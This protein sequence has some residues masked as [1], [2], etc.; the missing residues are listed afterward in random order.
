MSPCEMRQEL[1][2]L[3][4]EIEKVG[5]QALRES[6]IETWISAL[7]DCH[8]AP[9]VLLDMPASM[10]L[11]DRGFSLVHHVL[12]VCQVA[13]AAYVTFNQTFPQP[14]V[15]LDFDV[16]MAGALLHDV[17]KIAEL[18]K[19]PGGWQW[20]RQSHYVRHAYTGVYY[21]MKNHVPDSVLQIIA[22]H[23][24]EADV[25][26]RSAEAEVVHIADD[27]VFKPFFLEPA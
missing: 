13:E 3:L 23:S 24:G 4:P 17:G 11:K 25:I 15:K 14:P 22:Y 2:N 21:A 9:A 8:Q 18:E 20:R 6:V 16:L 5:C 27:M 12:G 1:V 10:K 19:T 26:P 7:E